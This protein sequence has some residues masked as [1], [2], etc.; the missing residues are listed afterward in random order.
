MTI[1]ELYRKIL[2]IGRR[3]NYRPEE[4]R[5]KF[6]D[7]LPLSW[8]EKAEDIGEHLPLDE[9]AKKLYEIELCRIA[10]HKRDRIPDP[11][12][13]AQKAQA[14]AP[15]IVEPVRQPRGPPSSLQS[16]EGLKNYYVAEYLKELGLFNKNDLDSAYPVKPFQR[17]RP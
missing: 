12:A 9:L 2:L 1:D 4:L 16:E 7:A 14:L 10:R 3:A 11:L 6:L 5:R 17:P 8:L 15:Q 13:V